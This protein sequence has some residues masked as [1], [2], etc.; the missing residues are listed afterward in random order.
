M[1]EGD[2][3]GLSAAAFAVLFAFEIAFLLSFVLAM[4]EYLFFWVSVSGGL[5]FVVSLII[6]GHRLINRRKSRRGFPMVAL[7]LGILNLFLVIVL[8]VL[9]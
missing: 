6:V 4:F 2:R 3:G 8:L 7:V 9:G 5:L 1:A